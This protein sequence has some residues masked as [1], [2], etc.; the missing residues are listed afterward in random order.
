VSQLD[1]ADVVVLASR[2]LDRPPR[3]VIEQCDLA[4]LER[5]CAV[6]SRHAADPFLA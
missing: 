4:A 6:Q 5:V 1:P 2:V 3:E